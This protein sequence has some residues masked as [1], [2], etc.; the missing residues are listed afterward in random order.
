MSGS[1]PLRGIRGAVGLDP[2]MRTQIVGSTADAADDRRRVRV[3][4]VGGDGAVLRLARAGAGFLSVQHDRGARAS[5]TTNP[6]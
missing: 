1:M 4:A 6:D 3:T 2:Q 5:R